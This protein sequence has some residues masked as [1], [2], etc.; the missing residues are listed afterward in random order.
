MKLTVPQAARRAG[1]SPETIRRWIWSGKLPSEK[2]GNQHFVEQETLDAVL[3]LDAA[4]PVE[5]GEPVEVPGKWG[6]WL[7]GV[8]EFQ[9]RL[10]AKGVR[11]PPADEMI[12]RSRR[13][14]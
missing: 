10:R 14:H 6:D 11:L 4:E 9:D 13:G 1:R 3:A 12:R 5:D 2:I 7:R 8:R